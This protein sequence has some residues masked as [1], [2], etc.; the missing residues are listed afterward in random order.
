MRN[1]TF[2]GNLARN[3]FNFELFDVQDIQ[4]T[5]NGEEMAYSALDLTG[6]KNHRCYNTRFSGIGDMNCGH[7]PEIA[8]VN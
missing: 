8:R 2:N 3:P 5:V 7:G 1:D 6:R 4:L